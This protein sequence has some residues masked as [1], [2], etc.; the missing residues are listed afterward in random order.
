MQ[1]ANFVCLFGIAGKNAEQRFFPDGNF[2]TT[3]S[4]A[5]NEHWKDKQTGAKRQ[6]TQWH[7]LVFRGPMAEHA[8]SMIEKGAK[9]VISGKLDYRKSKRPDGVEVTI[10]NILVSQ[11]TLINNGNQP[12]ETTTSPSGTERQKYGNQM[13]PN[14]PVNPSGTPST[15]PG[16]DDYGDDDIPF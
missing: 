10:A 12:P 8:A 15:Q 4:L 7:N 11:W 16:F 9:L 1:G 5:T 14:N 3:C 2:I 13:V 6:K